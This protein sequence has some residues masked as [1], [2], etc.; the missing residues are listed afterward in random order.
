MC[1]MQYAKDVSKKS[2]GARGH[3]EGGS[4]VKEVWGT[5]D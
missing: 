3:G 5:L 4:I 2:T 1:S